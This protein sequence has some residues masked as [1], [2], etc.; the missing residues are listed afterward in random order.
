VCGP[1]SESTIGGSGGA[2]SSG[3]GSASA[4]GGS[5]SA[6]GGN[7]TSTG[8]GSAD[9]CPDDAKTVYV[10][11]ANRTLSSFDPRTK[12]FHDIGTLS[13]P[14]AAKA[15]PFS[16]S[17]ARDATAYVLYDS[18]ELF[19]VSTSTAACTKT[20]F[21]DATFKNFGMGFSTDTPGGTTD[22][23]FIAGGATVG[24]TST[25]GSVNVGSFGA[26]P[27]GG[28]AGWPELTGTGD[29]QLWGFFPQTMM[30]GANP[31]VAQINKG[32]ASL[33]NNHDA[34]ALAGNPTAWAFAFWGGSFWIFL[35]RVGDPSTQVWEMKAS[36]GDLSNAL[37]STGRK[38]VGAGVSTCAPVT[39]N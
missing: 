18:G 30:G 33:S 13:C 28:I 23:L 1:G 2:S 25:L 8:G 4:G 27:L 22:T 35:E 37:S 16:M 21:N 12:T 3:G 24:M 10:V 5:S 19:A 14:A 20:S 36:T 38:I 29:A 32:D 9:G 39:I 26:T 17:V 6:G 15:Q 7:G 31:F 34:P 11:D